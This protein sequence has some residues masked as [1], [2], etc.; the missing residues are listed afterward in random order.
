MALFKRKKNTQADTNEEM[1]K[2]FLTAKQAA[3]EAPSG[4]IA[5]WHCSVGSLMGLSKEECRAIWFCQDVWDRLP[6]IEDDM[7]ASLVEMFF[8]FDDGRGRAV[9]AA[10]NMLLDVTRRASANAEKKASNASKQKSLR[11]DEDALLSDE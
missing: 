2:F 1:V 3:D 8:L 9:V 7:L 11:D 5:A 4:T 6:G 10:Y